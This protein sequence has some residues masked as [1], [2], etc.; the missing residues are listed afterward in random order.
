MFRFKLND[1]ES[2]SLDNLN[3]FYDYMII[4][5]FNEKKMPKKTVFLLKVDLN[6]KELDIEKLYSAKLRILLNSVYSKNKLVTI[7]L[8]SILNSNKLLTELSFDN[9]RLNKEI[10][11]KNLENGIKNEYLEF[12]I[13]DLFKKWI[14]HPESNN[15]VA[16][17]IDNSEGK[18][19]GE[20]DNGDS[21]ILIEYNESKV[22]RLERLRA[23]N[24]DIDEISN[25]AYRGWK[26]R[27]VNG[28]TDSRGETEDAG[29]T[30]I[31]D[32]R[33]ATEACTF[34]GIVAVATG[35]LRGGIIES[36]ISVPFND[37]EFLGGSNI[38]LVNNN[39]YISKSGIYLVDWWIQ[40]AEVS[41]V[42]NYSVTLKL[43]SS[44]ISTVR[45]LAL[46]SAGT[47]YNGNAIVKVD[48]RGTLSLV[49]SSETSIKVYTGGVYAQMRVVELS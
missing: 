31:T 8:C 44:S 47:Q 38:S 37:T 30:G 43:D 14:T 29:T 7:K 45:V 21:H 1:V 6:N 26:E 33:R 23:Y 15:G 9:L 42:E 25:L 32:E 41:V 3:R 27:I 18:I 40:T 11:S 28:V 35:D 12:D 16:I 20:N 2:F 10:E 39:I 49:N 13:T 17:L 34:N 22:P 36:G 48:G 19:E 5:R 24:S 4:E 46:S